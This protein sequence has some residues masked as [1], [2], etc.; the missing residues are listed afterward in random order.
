MVARTR[1]FF[2]QP[3][4]AIP[5]RTGSPVKREVGS[6]VVR[7]DCGA[8]PDTNNRFNGHS[9]IAVC[10]LFVKVPASVSFPRYG[11]EHDSAD[12]WRG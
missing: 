8:R 9:S 10:L 4:R 6:I 5:K 1:F 12:S 7:P 3:A 11:D 2:P